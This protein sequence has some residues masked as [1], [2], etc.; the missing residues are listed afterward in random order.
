MSRQELAEAVNA[1]L[2]EH[3]G[4]RTAIAARYIGGLERGDT[5][6]PSAHYR[7]ALRAVLGK[8]TDAELG[9]FVI[10][11]HAKDPRHPAE[12][13]LAA[14]PSNAVPIDRHTAV[15]PGVAVDPGDTPAYGMGGASVMVPAGAAAVQ[16]SVNGDAAFTVVCHDES[17]GGAVLAGPVHLLIDLSGTVA[18]GG[19]VPAVVDAPMVV[20]GARVYALNERQAR[21]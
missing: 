3:M 4:R 9:L 15:P 16:V 18:A 10:Q 21:S 5:R 19:V 13:A 7:A 14:G 1:W 20:G 11:G 6:W 2:Y 12:P 17:P 8:A